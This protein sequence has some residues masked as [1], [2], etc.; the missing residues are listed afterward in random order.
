M[1]LMYHHICPREAIPDPASEEHW[2]YI[3]SPEALERQLRELLRRGYSFL[4]LVEIVRAIQL[5]GKEPMRVVGVTFDD[6]WRDQYKYALPVL[7]KLGLT[8]TF[9]VTTDHI[10]SG[11]D[12]PRKMTLEHLRELL[13][14]GMTIGGHSRTERNL[15]RLSAVDAASEIAGCKADLEDAL[16]VPVTLFAYP[17]GEFNNSIVRIVREAGFEAACSAL[18]PARNNSW[19]LFWL[20][21][22]TLSEEMTA[23]RDSYRLSPLARG[24]LAYRVKR[25]LR[26]SLKEA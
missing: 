16:E 11:M 20:F 5:T 19:S 9:F 25:R 17:G 8:A 15:T 4:P 12:D 10:R 21:R 26:T 22:D 23:L 2:Q 6:S 24:L 18:G 13:D 3:H 1:I 7:R 14:S